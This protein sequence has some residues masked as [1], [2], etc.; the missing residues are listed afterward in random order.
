[1]P[2]E[3][4]ML[5]T[6]PPIHEIG[7]TDEPSIQLTDTTQ[8]VCHVD[9]DPN[10]SGEEGKVDNDPDYIFTDSEGS[11]TDTEDSII[12]END[13]CNSGLENSSTNVDGTVIEVYDTSVVDDQCSQNDSRTSRKR[14][15]QPA[16][17]KRNLRKKQRNLGNSYVDRKGRVIDEKR[18]KDIDCTKCRFQC[19]SKVSRE[20]QETLCKEYWLLGESGKQKNYI[21]SL[22]SEQPVQRHRKRETD[23]GRE[24]GKSRV[25][26]LPSGTINHHRVCLKFFCATLS[27]SFPVID[28]ALKN[29]GEGG[30]YQGCDKRIGKLPANSTPQSEKN[31]VLAHINSFPAMESHYC[32]KNSKKLYLAPDLNIT[33]MYSLYCKS[34]CPLEKIKPVSLYVYR[35]LFNSHD[36]QLSFYVPKKDQCSK[37]NR[38]YNA[39]AIEKQEIED[40]WKIHKQNESESMTM[41][42]E[43][44]ENALKDKGVTQRVISFDMQAILNLP[45]AGDAQI[46][47]KRKLSVFN[48]TI[49]D[50]FNGDGYC[51]VWDEINGC[52]GA[53]E[54]GTCLLEYLKNLPQS[55]RKVTSYSDTCGGQNRNKFTATAL[56]YA[57]NKFE[58]IEVF[59]MKF[60][61]SGHSYLEADSMHA[62]IERAKKHKCVYT[63]R[64]WAMLIEMAHRKPRPY[65]VKTLNN[66]SFHN[67][68]K[69]SDEILTNS[70]IDNDGQKVSWLKI[71]WMRFEKSKPFTIQY[72]YSLSETEFRAVDVLKMKGRS[73]KLQNWNAVKL[74]PKY[75]NKLPISEAKK[76]DLLSLVGNGIIPRDYTH[77]YESI[78]SK[79]NNKRYCTLD[80]RR[81]D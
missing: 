46:Y 26:T 81:V 19:S 24:K 73:L 10:S 1:M 17:W 71:K 61:E 72:K 37:C 68:Q 49:Y 31:H 15:A 18:P 57:V 12:E 32:R 2:S 11:V 53:S 7:P 39:T 21:C 79:K 56:L 44:K 52:K 77:F 41:K 3:D 51:Y 64:E 28:S 70:K 75:K 54:V 35:S 74:A 48:F 22:V 60:M 30:S 23:S 36:P 14:K 33:T 47:Y 40:E 80:R 34:Y 45:T 8:T 50:S 76:K 27:I 5:I 62:T 69:L 78:I 20:K 16:T 25:Y 43:D 58:N 42:A 66:D 55:V 59:D 65:I 4:V 6:I 63:T 9:I 29:K 67:L 38:Y 13:N